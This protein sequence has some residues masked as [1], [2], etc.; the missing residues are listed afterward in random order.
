MNID[1]DRLIEILERLIQKAQQDQ[2]SA[3]D[4]KAEWI[5][6]GKELAFQQVLGNLKSVSESLI[7]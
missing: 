6:K 7:K 3:Q 4:D 2:L 1:E 5:A